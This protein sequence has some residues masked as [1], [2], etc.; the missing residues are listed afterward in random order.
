MKMQKQ[1]GKYWR[2]RVPVCSGEKKSTYPKSEFNGAE[3]WSFSRK[4]IKNH[5]FYPFVHSGRYW[6]RNN[7]SKGDTYIVEAQAPWSSPYVCASKCPKN[8][9]KSAIFSA[10]KVLLWT[11]MSHSHNVTICDSAQ[12]KECDTWFKVVA[13]AISLHCGIR[14]CI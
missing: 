2:T 7:R 5:L 10:P 8:G 3:S 13:T 14:E 12:K 11:R 1:D 9:L 6:A 4:Y